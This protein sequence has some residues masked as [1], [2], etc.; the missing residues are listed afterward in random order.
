MQNS[1]IRSS[2]RYLCTLFSILFCGNHLWNRHRIH[3][4]FLIMSNIQQLQ[5]KVDNV[6]FQ[7]KS[8]VDAVE[9][10]GEQRE[11]LEARV[12]IIHEYSKMFQKTVPKSN[13]NADVELNEKQEPPD[14]PPENIK[15]EFSRG[16]K[17]IVELRVSRNCRR[18]H[19]VT[20]ILSFFA[21]LIMIIAILLTWYM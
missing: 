6:K 10:R 16:E 9:E 4:T 18:W 7:I 3:S 15:V 5:R 11:N 2:N 1:G 17:K 13:I 19:F 14:T 12:E 8:N 20:A 21:L